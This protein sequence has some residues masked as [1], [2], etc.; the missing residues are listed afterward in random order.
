MIIPL[1]MKIFHI[2]GGQPNPCRVLNFNASSIPNMFPNPCI[3]ECSREFEHIM[4]LNHLAYRLPYSFNN[5]TNV[6]KSLFFF[7]NALAHL[8]RPTTQ[9]THEKRSLSRS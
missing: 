6:T 9:H 1:M 3:Q 8:E 4:H 2:W 7:V 5:A